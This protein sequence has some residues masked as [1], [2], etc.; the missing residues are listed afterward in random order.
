MRRA[1][2]GL[3]AVLSLVAVSY[4]ASAA[5]APTEDDTLFQAAV[6]RLHEG[7]PGEAIAD[8]EALA[9]H[10]VLDAT[11]SFDR[12]LAYASRVRVGGE[13][14]GD[15]GEAAH[16]LLEAK[17]LA[18]DRG[19]A[20]EAARAL[21][22]VR[23]EVGRRRVRAGEPVEFD[24]GTALG[25][26]FLGL[27]PE[28]AWALL[29]LVGSFVLG[30]ALFVRRAASERRSQIAATVTAGIALLLVLLGTT[31]MLAARHRRMTVTQGVIVSAGARPTDE[32]GLVISSAPV[33]P[34]AAEVEILGLRA[35]WA[36]VRWGNLVAWIPAAAVRAVAGGAR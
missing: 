9:D 24:P 15:L 12:G 5:D 2:A 36:Q 26:A 8:F 25:P 35:G 23:A 14:A 16:G 11:V 20:G 29:A 13:Q 27:L 19:L 30:V 17:L 28:D 10:G 33:L 21:G 6:T 31:T 22:L 3:M 34:E 4:S 7:K 18:S 1:A 32:R